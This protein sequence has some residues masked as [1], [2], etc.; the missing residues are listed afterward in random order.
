MKKLIFILFIS[1]GF[2]QLSS[3]ER[4]V[5]L[6]IGD[7]GAGIFYHHHIKNFESFKL[8]SVIRWTD[9]RPSGEI[10]YYNYYTGTYETTNTVS[11]AMF[12]VFGTLNY[13]P[14]EGKIAN[15]FSPYLALKV[16]PVIILD[17]DEGINSFLDRWTNAKGSITYGSNIGVGIEF[18]QPGKIHYSI[19]FTYD[20]VPLNKSIDGYDNL[21][22]T[23]LTLSIHR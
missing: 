16:G 20:F 18:R 11:L 9:I 19:E 1:F 17:A 2:C 4:G 22:G 3:T 5:G 6:N 10:P 23:V 7:T 8:G 12:P 15:N 13:Y 14:F 21:N